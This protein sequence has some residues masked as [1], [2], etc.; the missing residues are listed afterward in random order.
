MQNTETIK[1]LIGLAAILLLVGWL[2]YRLNKVDRQLRG[3]SVDVSD[4]QSTVN[5]LPTEPVDC[6]CR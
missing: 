2:N 4:V 6:T 3:L 5:D 1:W